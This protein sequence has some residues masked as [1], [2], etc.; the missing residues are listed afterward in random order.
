MF[1]PPNHRSRRSTEYG[2]PIMLASIPA[3]CAPAQKPSALSPH[4]SPVAE[5]WHRRRQDGR[6]GRAS[7]ARSLLTHVRRSTSWVLPTGSR[8]RK[9]FRL[10]NICRIG[11]KKLWKSIGRTWRNW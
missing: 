9:G 3:R 7:H 10:E 2:L 1:T 6:I 11:T 8:E 4:P 5:S